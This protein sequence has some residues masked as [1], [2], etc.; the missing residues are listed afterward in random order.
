MNVDKIAKRPASLTLYPTSPDQ[1]DGLKALIR[2]GRYDYF[3]EKRSYFCENTATERRVEGG[4]SV[5]NGDG[6]VWRTG[7]VENGGVF[8]VP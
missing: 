2:F 8:T 6:G 3:G 1:T 4:D 7:D 5:E